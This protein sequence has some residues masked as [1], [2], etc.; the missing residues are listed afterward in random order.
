[1]HCHS[2]AKFVARLLIH[3]TGVYLLEDEEERPDLLPHDHDIFADFKEP[4]HMADQS[5][6]HDVVHFGRLLR[7]EA[8]SAMVGDEHR[9]CG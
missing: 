9:G 1:M 4:E 8:F 5:T 6:V 7:A 3:L 2:R